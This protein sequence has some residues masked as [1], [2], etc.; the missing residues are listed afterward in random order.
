MKKKILRVGV[1]LIAA[2]VLSGGI[3][4]TGAPVANACEPFDWV[5][6]QKADDGTGNVTNCF[7]QNTSTAM[8]GFNTATQLPVLMTAG[9]GMQYTGGTINVKM[10]DLATVSTT[11]KGLMS[12]ADKAKLDG[13]PIA[14]TFAYTTRTIGT[15]FQVSTISDAEVWYSVRITNVLNLSGGA[16]GDVVL[17]IAD[18]VGFTTNV[19]ELGRVG[20]GNTGTLVV[21][22]ALNDA[23]AVQV[24]GPVPM[25]KYVRLRTVNTTGTPTYTFL[26]SSER[27]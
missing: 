20:N 8:F 19:H 9:N 5:L 13:L 21:G 14:A 3:G 10:S 17:E 4:F 22:L 24:S 1:T 27:Y 23:I 2:L 18:N 7:S 6:T 12:S 16:A 11:T 26:S 25:G 15:A